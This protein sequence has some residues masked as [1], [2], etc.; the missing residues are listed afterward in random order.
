MSLELIELA[1]EKGV[2]L[3]CFPPHMTHIL[4]PLDVSIYH[5]LKQSW[6]AVLKRYKLESMAENVGKTVFPSL[7]K[8]LWEC[9]FKRC[10]LIAGFQACGLFPLDKAAVQGKLS[11]SIPFREPPSSDATSTLPSS[12]SSVVSATSSGGSASSASS[13]EGDWY[14]PHQGCMH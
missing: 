10:H 13:S 7:I 6:A 1:R 3:L 14:S 2:H 8:K 4:Q 5:P 12:S 11:A 9:S